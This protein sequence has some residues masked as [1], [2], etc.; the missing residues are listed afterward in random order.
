M[1]SG[2]MEEEDVF[3]KTLAENEDTEI[4]CAV[5]V[6]KDLTIDMMS[7][8]LLKSLIELNPANKETIVILRTVGGLQTKPLRS[9]MPQ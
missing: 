7:H 4:R 9:C 8:H 2:S 6:W 1:I 3:L 5:C